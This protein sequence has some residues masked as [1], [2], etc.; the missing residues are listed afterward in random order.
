MPANDTPHTRTLRPSRWAAELLGYEMPRQRSS[1]FQFCYSN[2]VPLIRVGKRKVLFSEAAV[3]D[4]LRRRS[5]GQMLGG[6]W[7]EVR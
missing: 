5:T 3:M 4:F 7:G 6:R 1:F 2:G